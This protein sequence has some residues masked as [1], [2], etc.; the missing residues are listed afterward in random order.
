[1]RLFDYLRGYYVRAP[2]WVQS[3]AGTLCSAMPSSLVYGK[4][5]RELRADIKRSEWM[6][7]AS[8]S[9]PACTS[10]RSSPAR[11]ERGITFE[12]VDEMPPAPRGKRVMVEQHLDLSSI[13]QADG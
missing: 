3:P 8:K 12:T 10:Q 11:D 13:G 7:R 6:P 2:R 4:I 1:M 5:F 9:G